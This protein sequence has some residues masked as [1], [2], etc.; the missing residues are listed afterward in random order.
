MEAVAKCIAAMNDSELPFLKG[1]E[2]LPLAEAKDSVEKGVKAISEV[3]EALTKAKKFLD[4]RTIEM[5]AFT[6]AAKKSFEEGVAGMAD[7]ISEGNKD[8]TKFKE[9]TEK[10]SKDVRMQEATE[11]VEALEKLA[12]E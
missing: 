8:L 2:V 3:Q 4:G 7:K 5:K 12:K 10:R 1:L 6:E 11:M 9:E